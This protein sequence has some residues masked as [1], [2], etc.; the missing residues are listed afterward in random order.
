MGE[1]VLIDNKWEGAS[2]KWALKDYAGFWVPYSGLK[3]REKR[4]GP[5]FA[6]G[7]HRQVQVSRNKFPGNSW[8]MMFGIS[9]IRHEGK[10]AEFFYPE[11]A[12]DIDKSTW[13]KFLFSETL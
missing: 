8:N 11:K 1:S 6:R 4:Q 9:A 2:E 7:T 5:K 13:R 12:V 10:R 3:D